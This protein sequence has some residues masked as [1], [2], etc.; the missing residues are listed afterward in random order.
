MTLETDF[1][2]DVFCLLGL[3]FDAVTL[4]GVVDEI[5]SS[6]KRRRSLFLSTPN[7]NYLIASLSDRE[8]RDSVLQS[9]LSVAD[10]MPVVWIAR[11]LRMPIRERISG[12]S[13]FDRL[14]QVRGDPMSVYIFGG[15]DGV[16]EAAC[17]RLNEASSG[18]NCV[19]SESPGFGSLDEL[20]ANA[21][22]ERINAS[23][24]N[25]LLLS[26]SARKGQAWIQRNRSRLTVPV[27]CNLGAT[28]NFVAGS[29]GR[30]PA[31]M[32]RT[33]LEW[34]W[35][36]KEEPQLWRRYF[37]D[38][39]ALIGLLATRV[40]PYA[41]HLK[42]HRARAN[43]VAAVRADSGED[44]SFLIR[45][46][47]AWT[48]ENMSPLRHCFSEAA[49]AGKDVT[50]EMYGVTYVD[51]AFVAL[52]LLL[53]GHQS[54]SSRRLKIVGCRGPAKKVLR[55]CCAEYLTSCDSVA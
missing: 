42:R 17:R 21:M 45:L 49:S 5:Q 12:S 24:A 2:R 14:R 55:Y 23:Q 33:G 18:L 32:Q 15:A 13:L 31:W 51:A 7:V 25:F 35:R 28:A 46:S 3:P 10:G 41:C 37:R 20:S 34:L 9:D 29:V 22:I 4:E 43:D 19:G 50:L 40:L 47:G 27:L 52:V 8:L 48:H 26:F 44:G 54:R 30:A 6:A 1:Q 53:R 11:L 36:I 16:A 38:G 39:I